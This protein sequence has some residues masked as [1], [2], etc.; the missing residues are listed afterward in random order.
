MQ[1]VKLLD[2]NNGRI[3]DLVLLPILEQVVINFPRAKDH[4]LDFVC[5]ANFRR[6]Q[7]FFETA[8]EEFLLGRGGELGPQQAFRCH[9]DERLDEV[10]FHLPAQDVKV[11]R[12]SRYVADLDVVFS[13]KL[14]ESLEPSAGM[15]RPLAF[16]AVWQQHNQPAWPLPL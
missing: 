10:A 15:F 6:G 8:I 11:L 4:T 9:D 14:Q 16:V 13:A 3:L 1:R 2:A 5:R 12:G 7:N